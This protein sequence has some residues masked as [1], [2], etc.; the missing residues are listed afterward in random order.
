MAAITL[1][2]VLTHA[3]ALSAE[4]QEM[5][6]DLLHK[7]RV[8]AWRRETAVE[9]RRAIKAFRSGKLKSQSAESVIVALRSG[10]RNQAA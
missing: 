1:D 8:D 7:R 3:E 4:D 9:A 2:R 10:L 6:E 5:L